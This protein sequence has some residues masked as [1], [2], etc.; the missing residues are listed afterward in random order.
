MTVTEL[1][2]CLSRNGAHKGN[3]TPDHLVTNEVLYQLSYAG[4][5]HGAVSRSR[6][7]DLNITRVVLYQLSYHGGKVGGPIYGDGW[8]LMENV[9]LSREE[10]SKRV[11]ELGLEI[12]SAERGSHRP[13]V[14]V[15]VLKGAVVFFSD[16]IRE[17]DVPINIAFLSVS[18]Y[19]NST[20]SS[21]VVQLVQDLDVNIQGRDVVL[22]EDIVDTGLT[23]SYLLDSLWARHPASIRVC[24]LLHK[25]SRKKVDVPLDFIGFT[26]PDKFV[27]GY[28]LDYNECSRNLKDICLAEPD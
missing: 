2:P 17:V 3:R 15:C 5:V 18:S 20:K 10:I 19:G 9:V 16:L 24:T 21:G 25:P 14:M 11:A 27:I 6:T 28:G 23:M 7:D 4:D 12:S 1:L 13:L 22:V 8:S 26:I